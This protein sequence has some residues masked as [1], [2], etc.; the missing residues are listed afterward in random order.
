MIEE[1][2]N[3]LDLPTSHNF[4]LLKILRKDAGGELA[5]KHCGLGH[6]PLP[7]RFAPDSPRF[8]I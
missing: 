5:S 7:M 8:R 3:L 1:S 4:A 6:A 2:I